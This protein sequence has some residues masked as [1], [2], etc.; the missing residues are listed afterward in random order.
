M[1]SFIIAGIIAVIALAL[2]MFWTW[3]EGM[4]T[5]PKYNYTPLRI[6]GWGCGLAA[7]VASSHWW[8]NIGW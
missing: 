1:W 6:L 5:A 7:F 3:G 2:A 4:A 8:P